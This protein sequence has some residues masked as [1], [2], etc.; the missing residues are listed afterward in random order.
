MCILNSLTGLSYL[1]HI[2]SH[3]LVGK[4]L[5]YFCVVKNEQHPTSSVFYKSTRPFVDGKEKKCG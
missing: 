3:K 5:I 1:G 2:A 4:A